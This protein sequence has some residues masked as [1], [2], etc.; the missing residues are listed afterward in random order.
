M[1]E[2]GQVG[3]LDPPEDLFKRGVARQVGPQHQ[4]VDEETDQVV[5]ARV[6]TSRDGRTQGDVVARAH[7]VQQHRDTGL[8]Q[9]EHA[10]PR[11]GADPAQRG[12][13]GGG[14]LGP[15]QPAPAVRVHGAGPVERQRN[16]LRQPFQD[17]GP[18]RELPCPV[19]GQESVLPE[20]VVRVLHGQRRPVGGLAAYPGLVGAIEVPEE[21]PV[22][23][24]VRGD[25][26]QDH[27]DD[28][29][30]VGDVE[31]VRPQRG[32]CREVESP[33]GDLPDPAVQVLRQAVLDGESRVSG[34]QDVL[35]GR[36]FVLREDG[37][38]CLV[39]SGD[40]GEGLPQG[41]HVEAAAQPDDQREVV[42]VPAAQPLGQP[43]AALCRRYGDSFGPGYGDD[44]RAGGLVLGGARGQGGGRGR[45]EEVADGQF[46]AEFGAGPA[47]QAGG[48]ERVAAEV[49]EAVLRSCLRQAEDFG[50]EAAEHLLLGGAGAPA[51]GGGH[52]FRVGQGGDVEFAVVVHRQPVEDDEGA[53]D[54]VVGELLA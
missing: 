14:H 40:V 23:P 6:G 31:Y 28:M 2:G 16:L 42:R 49:E 41:V 25:V 39:A 4:R 51:G 20:G 52:R 3:G 19:L 11:L 7:P 12:G 26:V 35:V 37:A 13:G 27:R 53:R 46:G 32:L 17:L 50:E 38:E 1:V 54:H 18:V 43:E 8:E 24:F 44:R 45:L 22:R 48:Q 30:V 29:V 10:G 5:Q 21:R 15:D 9:H 36:A 34:V 47:D 33:G